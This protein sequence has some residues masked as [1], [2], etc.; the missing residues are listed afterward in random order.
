[1]VDNRELDKIANRVQNVIKEMA[2]EYPPGSDEYNFLMD[3]VHHVRARV[4]D[5]MESRNG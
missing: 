5:L 4:Q 1:M 3:L 2:E